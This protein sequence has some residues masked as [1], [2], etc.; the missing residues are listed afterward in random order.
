M[1]SKIWI[2]MALKVPKNSK[3]HSY[4]ISKL[5]DMKGVGLK[6]GTVHFNDLRKHP[7]VNYS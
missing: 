1:D 2:G 4:T 3:E 7:D 6:T 5:S